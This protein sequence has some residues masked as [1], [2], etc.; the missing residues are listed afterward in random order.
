MAAP[1]AEEKQ[2][3]ASEVSLPWRIALPAFLI[4]GSLLLT[5]LAFRA[6]SHREIWQAALNWV[7]TALSIW[8]W[9]RKRKAVADRRGTLIGLH[10]NGE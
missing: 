2:S 10:L 7:S 4:A 9:F 1:E 6:H 8:I 5:F 3:L